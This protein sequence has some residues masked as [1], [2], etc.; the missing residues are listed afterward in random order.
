MIPNPDQKITIHNFITNL[1]VPRHTL[2]SVDCQPIFC[3]L[4]SLDIR[5]LISLSYLLAPQYTYRCFLLSVTGIVQW[6]DATAKPFSQT[7]VVQHVDLS[8]QDGSVTTQI[9]VLSDVFRHLT[10]QS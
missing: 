2:S 7:L 5:I 6:G 10:P 4:F 8:Q 3:F 1:P 9:T